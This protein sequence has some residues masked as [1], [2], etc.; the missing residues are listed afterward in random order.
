MNLSKLEEILHSFSQNER[1]QFEDFLGFPKSKN[2]QQLLKLYKTLLKDLSANRQTDNR[3]LFK[4]VF[5]GRFDDKKIRYAK[6]ELTRKAE[7]FLCMRELDEQP[8]LKDHLLG[9]V[10]K[11]REMPK[12]YS[13][14]YNSIIE[15]NQN[16]DADSFLYS[17]LY[18][19]THLEASRIFEKRGNTGNLGQVLR[20]L[21]YFFLAKKLQLSCEIT[22]LRNVHSNDEQ[23][24]FLNETVDFIAKNQ[25]RL[26]AY[27]LVYH[28]IFLTL[29]EPEIELHFKEL[30]DLVKRHETEFSLS[31]LREMYQYIMNYCIKKIN[32]GSTDYQH[33]LFESYKEALKNKA[34]LSEGF[35]P[36]WDYKNIVTISIRVKD[37]KWGY[38]FIHEYKDSLRKNEKSNAYTYNLAYWYFHNNEK[39]KAL[40]LIRDVQFTDL[41]YQLDTRV[42]LLKIYYEQ[43]EQDTLLYHLAAFKTFLSRNK[44]IS[45]YQRTIYSNLVRYCR[46]L[47]TKGSDSAEMNKLKAE[48]ES[49]RQVADIQWLLGKVNELI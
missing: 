4:A 7:R 49:K 22:N 13:S 12:N 2:T 33:V 34:L 35:L 32:L 14:H 23:V 45:T 47:A 24:L 10:L 1:I 46:I 20:N 5:S 19:H 26:P 36:Q 18:N 25:H 9:V 17:Y 39:N 27:V 37:L 21:D 15:K 8:G 6:T 11:K 31:E 3:I 48:I 40:S 44:L 41:Y 30:R 29:H 28:K 38:S 42:L 16:T 43:D